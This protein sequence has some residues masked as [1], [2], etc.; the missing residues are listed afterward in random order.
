MKQVILVALLCLAL[1]G[2]AVFGIGLAGVAAENVASGEDSYTNQA[3]DF[4]CE[5]TAG[6]A[7]QP[8]GSCPG[9]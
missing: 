5:K 4:T 7:R 2:C 6:S 1:P 9:N 3:L 8:D